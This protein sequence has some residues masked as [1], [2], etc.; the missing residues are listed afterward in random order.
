[1][2]GKQ[3]KVS[4]IIPAYNA[5]ETIT[6]T[7][8]SLHAQTHSDWEA[9]VIDDGSC[10]ATTIVAGQYAEQDPRI[11]LI[12]QSHQGA[13]AARNAGIAVARYDWLLFLDADDWLLSQHLERLTAA[14]ASDPTLDAVHCGWTRVAP[15]GELGRANF[16]PAS[17]DL[18]PAFT[19]YCAFQ[20][21]ACI[22]RHSIVERVGGFDVSFR[23]CQDWDLWQRVARTG[24]RFGAV[25]EVLAR[26]R[27]RPGSISLNGARVHAD[28][29]RVI[30]QGHAPD[31][32]VPN[33]NPIYANGLPDSRLSSAKFRF[34]CWTGALVLGSG[35]DARP[36]FDLLGDDK[37]PDLDPAHVANCLFE[38]MLLPTGLSVDDWYDLWLKVHQQLVQFLDQL[39]IQSEACGL[40]DRTLRLLE[41]SVLVH[42]EILL[43]ATLG[44]TYAIRLE[45]TEPIP[46]ID[47]PS[48][49]E[50]LL[51]KLELEGCKL[52]T[53]ELLVSDGFVSGEA[54]AEAISAEYAWQILGQFFE[55]SVYPQLRIEKGPLGLSIWRRNIC[56]A[57]LPLDYI[58]G[59]WSQIHKEVGWTIF[60]QEIWARPDWPEDYFYDPKMV[61]TSAIHC[62]HSERSI[63]V[64][65]SEDLPDIFVAGQQLDILFT[66]GGI[67]LGK[68][69]L[70]ANYSTVL[71]QELRVALT[72]L[73][74]FDLCRLAVREGLLGKPLTDLLS[75]RERLTA[76]AKRHQENRY[77]TK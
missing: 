25:R 53:V 48:P 12:N 1:M 72:Q 17:V 9:I 56:L 61:E 6:E 65:V 10:D 43:P 29:L 54:I 11:Q 60:L 59:Y 36:L 77:N 46:D 64:E 76:S 22:V 47:T 23:S 5:A 49:V 44:A 50:Q 74:G 71:A 13:C 42:V 32:R 7:L 52:G 20:P 69:T 21:H 45:I 39:E 40:T 37:D 57:N 66:V 16:A 34:V 27:T 24:A 3:V 51:C 75:L 26:Y 41:R 35:E 8:D 68:I 19:Q 73:G 28:G 58:D 4:V 63:T 55:R 30:T 67:S 38:A 33:P 62:R 2:L 15:N 31:P 14:L 18:F 70:A